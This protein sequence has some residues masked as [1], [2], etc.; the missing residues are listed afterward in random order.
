MFHLISWL[1]LVTVCAIYNSKK[2]K[3]NPFPERRALMSKPKNIITEYRNYYLPLHFPVLLLSG[4]YWK[5]SDIP[6]GRLHFHNCLEIGV[7]HTDGGTME[8]Y[9][10][11]LTFQAGDV[12]CIPRNVPHTTYS[13]TGTESLWSYLFID[14]EELFRNLLPAAWKNYDLSLHAFKGYKHILGKEEYP[15]I[16]FLTMQIIRELEEQK[17]SYQISVRGLLLSLYISLYRIQ[18]LESGKAV[19]ED[20]PP[21][22]SLVIAPALDYI[23]DNYMQPFSM[24]YLADLCHWSPTHFRRV[25]HEIMGTSPLEYVN[26]TRIMKACNL[27]R[28]T[29]DSILDI[30][31]NVGFHSISSFN[32]YFCKVMQMSPREYRKQMIQ[33]DKRLEN[34]SILEYAGWMYP[35]TSL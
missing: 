32:R 34:Q 2:T 31:E 1:I 16:Y 9:G 14:P 15:D 28:S 19:P 24:E 33:T 22:N 13:H 26:N 10:E 11:P 30:S 35:E 3:I 27:I 17:P 21:E 25:F 20:T 23:E 5:I 8:F 12:T 6:S 29:E 18:N 4:D 7:C